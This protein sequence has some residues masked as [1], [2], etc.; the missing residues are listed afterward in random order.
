MTVRIYVTH[1]KP[2]KIV[3]N[4]VITPIH[5]G[6]T[7]AEVDLGIQG[8]DTG[9]NISHMNPYLCELTTQYWAWKNSSALD[10]VGFMHYRR[11]FL[12]G[13]PDG[14]VDSSTGCVNVYRW[15]KQYERMI[16]VDNPSLINRAIEG[17]DV[18]LP[19]RF[20]IRNW[21]SDTVVHQLG[22][23]PQLNRRP[24]YNREHVERALSV[25]ESAEPDYAKELHEVFFEAGG[26]Y[27]FYNAYVMRWELFHRYNQWL[28]PLLF[29]I[30]D[31]LDYSRLT[32]SESRLL[33][34]LA[35][36]LLNVYLR[37]YQRSH[38][39][40]KTN[41]IPLSQYDEGMKFLAHPGASASLGAVLAYKLRGAYM[42]TCQHGPLYV[43]RR[44]LRI[45]T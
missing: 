15:N 34:F 1:H 27:Y 17:Y 4:R 10:Y 3:Q 42:E 38:G 26:E 23:I 45:P 31:E 21:G 36:R 19:P 37:H 20:P 25:V 33:G 22:T 14:V 39:D 9:D 29:A 2:G 8:D 28:F 11:H 41:H 40:L 12:F 6:K 16:A 13:Q 7:C 43:V 24:Q 18:V 35:E 5:G 32:A 44:V 30:H